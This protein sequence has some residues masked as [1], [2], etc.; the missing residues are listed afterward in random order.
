MIVVPRL[1][2][3]GTLQYG[4]K[5]GAHGKHWLHHSMFKDSLLILFAYIWLKAFKKKNWFSVVVKNNLPSSNSGE[6]SGSFLFFY[7]NG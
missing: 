7:S 6:Y 2:Q 3:T 1:P 5:L 4:R